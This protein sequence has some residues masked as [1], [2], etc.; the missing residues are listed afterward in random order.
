ML[1]QA[2][3]SVVMGISAPKKGETAVGRGDIE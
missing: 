2:L 3:Q 1:A